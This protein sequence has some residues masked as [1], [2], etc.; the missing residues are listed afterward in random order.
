MPAV[1]ELFKPVMSTVRFPDKL[2]VPETNCKSPGPMGKLPRKGNRAADLF[3][4][5]T[6]AADLFAV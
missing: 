2:Q 3:A 6:R 4:V 5:A 1:G